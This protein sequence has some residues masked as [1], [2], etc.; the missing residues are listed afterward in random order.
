MQAYGVLHRLSLETGPWANGNLGHDFDLQ[1][2]DY[3]SAV[4]GGGVLLH[5][6]PTSQLLVDFV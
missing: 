1:H 6:S 3:I 2:V 5:L 4:S